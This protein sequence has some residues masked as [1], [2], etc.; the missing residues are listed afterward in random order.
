[1][2]MVTLHFFVEGL[3]FL[4]GGGG[5]LPTKIEKTFGAVFG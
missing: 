3:L 4:G 1:M 2:W 5:K